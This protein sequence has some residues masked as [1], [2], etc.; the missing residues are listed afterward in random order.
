MCR[1]PLPCG[2]SG[3]T[4]RPRRRCTTARGC[5]SPRS[6]RTNGSRDFDRASPMIRPSRA[7]LRGILPVVVA[8]SC[9]ARQAP[10][11]VATS[12]P[13]F[14]WFEYRGDDSVY[15]LNP[16]GPNDYHNPIIA[17]FHP[18]PTIIRAGDD[19]YVATSSFAYFPGVPLFHS[20]DLVNWTQIGH[21]LD[22]P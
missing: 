4:A 7:A 21:I 13:R 2:T 19:Y 9:H 8:L 15:R 22:R 6:E 5:L 18:D 3:P 10:K 20:K 14:D 12:D 11:P 16:A 17:G 1:S